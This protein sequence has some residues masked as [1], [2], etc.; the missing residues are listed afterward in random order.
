MKTDDE[1]RVDVEREIQWEP[2]VDARRIGVSAID[3]IVT[4]SGQVESYTEKWMTE[5][6]VERVQGVAGLANELEVRNPAER[7]DTDIAEAALHALTWNV[8]VPADRVTV[9]VE[10]GWLT[11]MGEVGWD[12]ERRAA[13][14]AVR[15]LWG[16]NG[17]SNLITVRPKTEP[18]EDLKRRIDATFKRAAHYD[19]KRLT[20]QVSGGVVT[21]RGSVHS[22]H[23]RHEAEKAVWAAPGVSTVHNYIS[24][25]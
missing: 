13:E 12:F 10:K 19:A 1:L 9:K 5:R 7:S 24:V 14:G 18:P 2:G 8:S 16:I 20:V 25:K 3:G 22:W 4:I 21:L 17:V 23:E 6:A 11:L 15:P